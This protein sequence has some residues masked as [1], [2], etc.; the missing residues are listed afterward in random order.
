MYKHD[1]MH[2]TTGRDVRR[3]LVSKYRER[4]EDRQEG[5]LLPLYKSGFKMSSRSRAERKDIPLSGSSQQPGAIAFH[6]LQ[7]F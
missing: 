2:R 3:R 6:R 5:S 4:P 7:C 1:R